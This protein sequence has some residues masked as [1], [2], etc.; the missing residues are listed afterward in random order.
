[1]DISEIIWII[2]KKN[3]HIAFV[4]IFYEIKIAFVQV[5]HRYLFCSVGHIGVLYFVGGEEGDEGTHTSDLSNF[6]LQE[7]NFKI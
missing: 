5:L 3:K 2:K 1:M 4:H 7:K 6:C